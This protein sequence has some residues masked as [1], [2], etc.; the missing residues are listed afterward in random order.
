M[1]VR[2]CMG[3][4]LVCSCIRG[5]YLRSLSRRPSRLR[6]HCADAGSLC[7][8]LF[9]GDRLC[10]AFAAPRSHAPIHACI[11]YCCTTAVQAYPDMSEI[12]NFHGPDPLRTDE[13]R[14]H[15]GL[16]VVQSAPLI[17]GLDMANSTNMDRIWPTGTQLFFPFFFFFFFFFFFLSFFGFLVVDTGL[18]G[19]QRLYSR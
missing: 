4:V 8:D 15:W 10:D 1:C 9:A 13:E 17:L 7:A 3:F 2:A 18:P 11:Q 12:G 16:W 19:T 6:T 5:T 14:T